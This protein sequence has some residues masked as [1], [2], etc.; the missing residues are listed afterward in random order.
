MKMR[1]KYDTVASAYIFSKRGNIEAGLS[2][3][4]WVQELLITSI[5]SFIERDLR[6]CDVM[7][8]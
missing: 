4:D 7:Q 6:R 3:S 5:K 8:A 2:V 1:L